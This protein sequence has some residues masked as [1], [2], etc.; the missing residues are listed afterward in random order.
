M[1]YL[2][3]C[4]SFISLMVLFSFIDNFG[5]D[6]YIFNFKMDDYISNFKVVFVGDV[7]VGKTQI[8][9]RIIKNTFFE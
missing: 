2:L 6:D 4:R 7:G 1:K 8:I 9:N 5:M 3:N